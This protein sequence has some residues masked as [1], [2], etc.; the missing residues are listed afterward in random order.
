MM[1]MTLPM[2]VFACYGDVGDCGD[3]DGKG[4]A[5]MKV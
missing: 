4:S 2:L 5:L 3:F 1:M